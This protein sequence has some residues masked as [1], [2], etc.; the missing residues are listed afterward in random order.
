MHNSPR[1][2]ASRAPRCWSKAP[3]IAVASTEAGRRS[4]RGPVCLWMLQLKASRGRSP[5]RQHCPNKG[6][7]QHTDPN[8]LL[9][10]DMVIPHSNYM[11]GNCSDSYNPDDNSNKRSSE[12]QFGISDNWIATKNNCWAHRREN[13]FEHTP[14]RRCWRATQVLQPWLLLMPTVATSIL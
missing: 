7:A 9:A 12:N 4:L 2:E 1:R 3:A 13:N 10:S 8:M 5:P 14:L 11:S 6:G